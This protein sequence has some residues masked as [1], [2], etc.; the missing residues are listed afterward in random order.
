[1]KTKAKK[2]GEENLRKGKAGERKAVRYLKRQGM[3]IL[4]RNYRA[5]RGEIDIVAMDG[6]TLVFAEVKT[7]YT[8]DFG[9]PSEAV[10]AFKQR[11]YALAAEEYLVKNGRESAEC[12]FDVLE[13]KKDGIN[14]IKAAFIT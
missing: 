3:Q 10:D 8:C 7:R 9:E 1:M 14:H 4:A 6:E 5:L 2:R 13:V 12:R 11:K